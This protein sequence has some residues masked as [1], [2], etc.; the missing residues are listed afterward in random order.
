MY[1]T[2][3]VGERTTGRP[4]SVLGCFRALPSLLAWAALAS[5]GAVQRLAGFHPAVVFLLMIY[6][7]P[8]NL[9][10]ERK[11]LACPAGQP[12]GDPPPQAIQFFKL[13]CCL[14]PFAAAAPGPVHG[15][16]CAG[17]LRPEHVF[18]GFAIVH[19]CPPDAHPVPLSCKKST[20]CD[21]I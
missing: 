12:G 7:L 15:H 5:A 16:I 17:L 9:T 21:T 20:F 18:F 19:A 8:L 4:G 11:N 14:C 13:S 1:V 3:F 10:L 2:L 6:F